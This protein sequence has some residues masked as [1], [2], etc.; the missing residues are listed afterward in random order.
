MDRPTWLLRRV[1]QAE[2]LQGHAFHALPLWEYSSHR[3]PCRTVF[4]VVAGEQYCLLTRR[5]ST[6]AV[7][8][9]GGGSSR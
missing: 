8:R 2:G 9:V 7:G 6:Y 4:R 1:E 3:T 5:R